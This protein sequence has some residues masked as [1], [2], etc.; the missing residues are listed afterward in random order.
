MRN[1]PE[2]CVGSRS[3]ARGQ[4]GSVMVIAMVTLSGLLAVAALTLVKVKRGVNASTQARFQSM[5]LF[6][7]ES[8]IA[9]GMDYLRANNASN[10]FTAIL[11]STP[12][13]ATGI[14]GNTILSGQTGS[15]F[16]SDV[17]MSYTVSILNNTDDPSFATGVDSDNIVILHVVGRGPGT[18]MVVLEVATG[19]AP[20]GSD[21]R[22]CPGYA[23][24]NISEDGSGRNDCLGTIIST[25]VQTYTPGTP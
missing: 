9:A 22:P 16:S 23:Q 21:G 17:E 24:G 8:G 25:D 13:G 4:R 11:N 6:A 3:N 20:L 1:C 12:T 7:A 15:L 2:K 18:S 10:N 5:A 19:G 14:A